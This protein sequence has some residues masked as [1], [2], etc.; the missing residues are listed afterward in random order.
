LVGS[1]V[2]VAAF[3]VGTGVATGVGVGVALGAG[4]GVGVGVGFGVLVGVG[5]GD[6]VLIAFFFA[7]ILTPFYVAGLLHSRFTLSNMRI[8]TFA[9][10]CKS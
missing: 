9:I 5:A 7:I 4:V 8:Y 3:G 1:G 6:G 2:L 10:F